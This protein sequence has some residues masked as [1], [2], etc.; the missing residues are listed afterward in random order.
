MQ[1]TESYLGN[2]FELGYKLG[3]LQYL[4]KQNKLVVNLY[5][6]HDKNKIITPQDKI[7][8]IINHIKNSCDSNQI[9]QYDWFFKIVEAFKTKQNLLF[10]PQLTDSIHIKSFDNSF[11]NIINTHVFNNQLADDINNLNSISAYVIGVYSGFYHFK[12]LCEESQKHIQSVSFINIDMHTEVGIK[13]LA[14]NADLLFYFTDKINKNIYLHLYELKSAGLKNFIKNILQVST[15]DREILIPRC[16]YSYSL[17]FVLGN[18]NIDTFFAR[19]IDLIN[20]HFKITPII[21]P[22]LKNLI[23]ASTYLLNYLSLNKTILKST[24]EITYGVI[25]ALDDSLIYNFKMDSNKDFLDKLDSYA[26]KMSTFYKKCKQPIYSTEQDI[27]CS[28]DICINDVT[29]SNSTKQLIYKNSEEIKTLSNYFKQQKP[30]KIKPERNIDDNRKHVREIIE[31]LWFNYK[32]DLENKNGK[33]IKGAFLLHSMG[34]GKTT[35]SRNVILN[36]LDK[37]KICY[38]YFAPRKKLIEQEFEKIKEF[39]LSLKKDNNN[40]C[41]KNNGKDENDN[42][43]AKYKLDIVDISDE[44]EKRS[45]KIIF[46]FFNDNIKQKHDITNQYKSQ[47]K[48]KKYINQNI[49]KNYYKKVKIVNRYHQQQNNNKSGNLYKVVT[50]I[51]EYLDNLSQNCQNE[52]NNLRGIIVLLTTQSLTLTKTKREGNYYNMPLSDTTEH[53]SKLS[54]PLKTFDFHLVTVFDEITGSDN[55]FYALDKV[56]KLI[57]TNF[58]RAVILVFDANLHSYNLLKEAIFSY[59]QREYVPQSLFVLDYNRDG[60]LELNKINFIVKSGYSYPARTVQVRQHFHFVY[61]DKTLQNLHQSI[62]KWLHDNILQEMRKNKERLFVYIQDKNFIE[63]LKTELEQL[64]YSVC[65]YNSS[66]SYNHFG[67]IDKDKDIEQAIQHINQNVDVVLSTSTLSRGIDLENNFTKV[68]VINT[69]YE[70]IEN[71]LAEKLQAIAR[72]RGIKDKDGNIIDSLIDKEIIEIFVIKLMLSQQS[73]SNMVSD[74]IENL[75]LDNIHLD[76]N[77]VQQHALEFYKY[78]T[79]TNIK[80][81]AKI[82]LLTYQSF[83]NP[84]MF[85]NKKVFIPLSNQF[86]RIYTPSQAHDILSVYKN[87]T[88]IARISECQ[89]DIRNIITKIT[90]LL[91]EMFYFCNPNNQ[92]FDVVYLPYGLHKNIK[93]DINTKINILDNV[94][95]LLDINHTKLVDFLN[96]YNATDVYYKLNNCLINMSNNSSVELSGLTYIP[97]IAMFEMLLDK[98]DIIPIKISKKITRQKIDVAFFDINVQNQ[99][100]FNCGRI[101]DGESTIVFFPVYLSSNFEWMKGEY[102][103]VDPEFFI[104]IF[105]T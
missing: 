88:D 70:G 26:I 81:Y 46:V 34:S 72:I 5:S 100:G 58:S 2:F 12:Y 42:T 86:N 20:E 23:Q 41:N 65:S 60:N 91:S 56:T 99:Y 61:S 28:N 55:G 54:L 31:E 1:Y 44:E 87:F 36:D 53:L 98:N 4:C 48:T 45:A 105:Q 59:K 39:L 101:K 63:L 74:I 22:D 11:F 90:S 30:I 19:F 75:K 37:L 9:L 40:E 49:R 68:C 89:P 104:N 51:K 14:G 84:E 13:G 71:N 64:G 38:L 43:N 77:V 24:A 85:S 25:Y 33:N 76:Y 62:A 8:E 35:S 66:F 7:F 67:E 78:R 80:E 95:K 97:L 6:L 27:K 52:F 10:M 3:I 79:I 82:S 102:P 47:N 96:K 32:N 18:Y 92:P 103:K 29:V 73:L 50:C 21:N 93:I 94:L 83:I 69:H 17:G 15:V 16:N 57:E